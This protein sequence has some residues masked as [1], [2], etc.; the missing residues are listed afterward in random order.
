MPLN[1]YLKRVGHCTGPLIKNTSASALEVLK[2][3][4]CGKP[5]FKGGEEFLNFGNSLHEQ[6]L[7]SKCTYKTSDEDCVRIKKMLE[8]LSDHVVVK[9]LMDRS[10]REIKEYSELNGVKVAYI[11]D[12]NKPHIKTGADLKTTNATN[13]NQCVEKALTFGYFRQ[14]VV[15]KKAARLKHFYFI[16]IQK[17]IPHDI[18]ILDVSLYPEYEA[19]AERELE[20]LLYFYKHYGN[21]IKKGEPVSPIQVTEVINNTLKMAKSGKESLAEIKLV[22]DEHKAN[23]RNAAKAAT[24]AEKSKNKLVKLIDRFPAKEREL[25]QEKLEKYSPL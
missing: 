7:Q 12:I 4:L 25:Y 6:F 24:L 20:F 16:F 23:V 11:L 21:V 8:R 1:Y 17:E 10:I 19:Y 22:A 9:S 13:F 3:Y 15:Y 14:A 2:N 5:Q 18:F